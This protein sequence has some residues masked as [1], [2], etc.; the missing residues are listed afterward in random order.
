[1]PRTIL[2]VPIQ[3]AARRSSKSVSG[4][5]AGSHSVNAEGGGAVGSVLRKIDNAVGH[6][7][8][9]TGCPSLSIR[10]PTHRVLSVIAC[11]TI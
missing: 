3:L 7:H 10:T 8:Q 6:T 2:K 4:Y 9:T 1:M 11:L 5:P